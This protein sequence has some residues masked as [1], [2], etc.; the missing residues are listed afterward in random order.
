MYVLGLKHKNTI[1]GWDTPTCTIQLWTF[2][3]FFGHST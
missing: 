1:L 3:T 2:L